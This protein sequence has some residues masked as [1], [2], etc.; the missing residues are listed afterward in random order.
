[1]DVKNLKE[2]LLNNDCIP[3]VLTELGCHSIKKHQNYYTCA[4]PDGD[5]KSAITV[6]LNEYI[7]VVNYTRN[8]SDNNFSPDIFSL[9]QFFQ[10]C[11]FNY[12]LKFVCECVGLDYYYDFEQEKPDSLK[13]TKMLFDMAEDRK[14]EETEVLKPI[15]KKILTYY[16]PYVNDL[17]FNDGIDYETQQFFEIGYDD[18]TNRITIPIRD[19]IGNLVGVKGR[20]FSKEIGIDENK[21]VYLEPCAKSKV[22]YGL[23]QNDKYIKLKG[24][25]FVG[26]SEKMVMQTYS[27]GYFNSV[28]LGGKKI[29]KTQIEYLTRMCVDIIFCFDKDVS[30]DEIEQT[31]KMFDNKVPLYYIQD[32]DNILKDKESPSDN[33]E[34]WEYLIKNNIYKL[35]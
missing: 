8:I 7:S 24:S 30:F 3:A 15:S 32:K 35:N 27:Y 23:Y 16:N 18:K 22:L 25:V 5:N 28:A 31:A 26:E 34:K 14:E 33:K 10:K 4:N 20:L 13:I 19:E 9:V 17:F 11:N 2:Y 12:A 29:S 21:Y 6:Y 1:M